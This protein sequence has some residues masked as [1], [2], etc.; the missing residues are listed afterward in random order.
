MPTTMPKN[1]NKIKKQKDGKSTKGKRR[2][3]TAKTADK[4]ELYQR[5][6]NSPDNDVEFLMETYRAMR[7][8]EPLHMR[9][10]FCGTAALS[11]EWLK[12]RPEH[13]AE[14]F[15][16]DPEPVEWG[17]ERN[18]KS[19][20]DGLARMNFVM[21]DARGPSK[22]KPDVRTAA[23]F[24]YWCFKERK[25]LLAYF[26]SAYE[27]LPEGGI[28]VI[29]M[30]G[31]PD[32]LHEM[33]EERDIGSGITYVW[34]Q[35][36]YWPGTGDYNASIHFKFKDGS[37]L[38]DA[39]TYEWRLWGLTELRDLFREAGFATVD[40]YF[41]GTDEDGESGDGVFA[42]DQKGE[43]CEAWIAYLVGGK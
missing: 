3:W 17:K 36:E 23:N 32:A 5:S 2:K 12:Q 31:G 39:F 34:D 37:K 29:D 15:D 33:N 14:G 10:D 16:I 9:E 35:K 38:K 8:R 18:F 42:L 13:T 19:V 6:V 26:K 22:K 40:S 27:D 7:G 25:E 30:Y 11:A 24:S 1:K 4:Y 43:N 20:D 28:F 21:E 41:E